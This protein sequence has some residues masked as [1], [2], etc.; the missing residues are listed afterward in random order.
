VSKVAAGAAAAV[1]QD[2]ARDAGGNYENPNAAGQS[3]WVN[4]QAWSG[5]VSVPIVT[6]APGGRD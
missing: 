6:L 5:G 3:G 4:V 2:G 1:E